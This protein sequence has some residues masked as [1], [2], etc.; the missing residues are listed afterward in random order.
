VL[1]SAQSNAV[2]FASCPGQAS[3]PTLTLP[4]LRGEGG[5]GASRE[6]LCL[7]PRWPSIGDYRTEHSPHSALFK[8]PS[9][10]FTFWGSPVD[11]PWSPRDPVVRLSTRT[12][13]PWFVKAYSRCSVT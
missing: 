8:K 3:A 2:K 1:K 7:I 12:Q 11:P 4:R 13:S 6:L 9:M 10:I 5:E